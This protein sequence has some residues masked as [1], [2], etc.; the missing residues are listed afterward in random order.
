MKL[1]KIY[2]VSFPSTRAGLIYFQ[3]LIR[4][5][6]HEGTEMHDQQKPKPKQTI[7]YK[8]EHFLCFLYYK[9]VLVYFVF[10]SA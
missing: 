5:K 3:K 4:W 1:V 6:N 9:F 8:V 2:N 7:K 10:F